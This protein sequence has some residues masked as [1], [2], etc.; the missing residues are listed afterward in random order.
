MLLKK[1]KGGGRPGRTSSWNSL[2]AI[3]GTRSR[4]C[5]SLV[6]W[7][8]P[9]VA[10]LGWV[11]F[12][13]CFSMSRPLF[14]CSVKVL[15]RSDLYFN[16]VHMSS[17]WW[18]HDDLNMYNNSTSTRKWQLG[19]SLWWVFAHDRVNWHRMLEKSINLLFPCSEYLR[20]LVSADCSRLLHMHK[21]HHG[22]L[23]MV[24]SIN[25]MH[26]AWKNNPVI[27]VAIKVTWFHLQGRC[28]SCFGMFFSGWPALITTSTSWINL[29]FLAT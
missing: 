6:Q 18:I 4:L 24:G 19:G 10:D 12:R 8:Y 16:N 9:R 14:L 1:I 3:H 20:R 23:G 25:C 13:C 21:D 2:K 29:I 27:L 15:E 22:F 28:L 11:F 17:E 5:N 26:K 7:W